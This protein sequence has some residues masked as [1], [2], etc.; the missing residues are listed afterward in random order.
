MNSKKICKLIGVAASLFSFL[1]IAGLFGGIQ[2]KAEVINSTLQS[3][4][5]D[6][7]GP[8]VLISEQKDYS[9]PINKS[10]EDKGIKIEIKDITASKNEMKV[11]AF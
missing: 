10:F 8:S 9:L 2:V 11:K 5:K 1:F 4:G 7:P 6:T 3:D